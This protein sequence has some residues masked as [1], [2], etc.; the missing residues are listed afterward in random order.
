MFNDEIK[1]MLVQVISSW[2]VLAVTGVL[3]IYIFIVN[4]V[5]RTY[6]SRRP[7]QPKGKRKSGN[8]Q[9]PSPSAVSE[10]DELGLEDIDKKA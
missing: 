10:T 2:Q 4:G 9:A 6:R 5:A 1:K 8:T 7:P 3:V